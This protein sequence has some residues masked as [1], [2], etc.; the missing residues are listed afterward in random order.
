MTPLIPVEDFCRDPAISNVQVSPGGT[1]V[2]LLG[3]WSKRQNIFVMD[4]AT[5]QATNVTSET[6]LDV[7]TYFWKSDRYLIYQTDAGIYRCDLQSGTTIPLLLADNQAVTPV[8]LLKWSSDTDVLVELSDKD[9]S[10]VYRTNVCSDDR[11]LTRVAKHPDPD[12]FGPVFKW[13]VDDCGEVYGAITTKGIN[14][15]LHTRTDSASPFQMVRQM[16]FRSSIESQFHPYLFPTADNQHIFAITRTHPDRDTAAVVVLSA[17]T[18]EEIRSI[19]HNPEVDVASIGYS[20][21]RKVVTYVAFHNGKLRYKVLDPEIAPIFETLKQLPRDH[22]VQIMDNDVAEKKFIVLVCNDTTP[23]E[24]YLLDATNTSH[25]KLTSLGEIA[26]WLNGKSLAPVRS[27][28][29]RAR[30]GLTIHGYLTFPV[31]GKPKGM[32]VYVHGGPENRNYWYYDWLYS[33]EVQ[34]L[35]NRGYA[36][37]QLNF[38][39][40]IGYGRSFWT[41]GFK[42]RGGTMLDDV[43]DGVHWLIKEGFA[44]PNRIVICGKSYGGYAALAG[45]AFTPDLYCAAVDYS[46][47]SNWLTWLNESFPPGDVLYPQFCVKVGDPTKDKERLEAVAPALHADK[48]TKPVFIAHGANDEDVALSES[49][50][51]VSALNAVGKS[52]DFKIL[53]DE[54]HIFQKEANKVAIYRAVEDF[55]AKHLG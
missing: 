22:V 34:F 43:T 38:R 10:D 27:V 28:K 53:K 47:V 45:V 19:Y 20:R 32:I 14:D 9:P 33:S 6:D 21:K 48:I 49:E 40:S 25:H 5:N 11:A 36:I 15:Y 17:K 31:E 12:K 52:P 24:Y 54:A 13:L 1:K 7:T 8:D 23:G 44:D 4:V 55:L 26:P 37:F 39:G 51:M 35:A 30:D 18:G 3:L 46:G 50:Q 41:K 42:E 29:F 2:S 16:D